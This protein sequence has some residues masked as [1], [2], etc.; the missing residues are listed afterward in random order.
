M[1]NSVTSEEFKDRMHFLSDGDVERM[2]NG[3]RVSVIA[4]VGTVDEGGEWAYVNIAIAE[5]VSN[6][7]SIAYENEDGDI[8]ID[9]EDMIKVVTPCT[10]SSRVVDFPEGLKRGDSIDVEITLGEDDEGNRYINVVRFFGI[11]RA[12]R[13]E[14]KDKDEVEIASHEPEPVPEAA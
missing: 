10:M 1:S 2:K 6:L 7:D 8:A 14:G 4:T 13:S 11:K 9:Y 5:E 12:P 3:N